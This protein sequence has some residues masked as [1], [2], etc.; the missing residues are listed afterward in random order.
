MILIHTH[1]PKS[2]KRKPTKK[3]R[4]LKASWEAMLAK[5]PSK[6]VPKHVTLPKQTSYQRETVRH[7]SLNSGLGTAT[8]K[9]PN[10]YTGTMVRGIATMH[11]SNAVPVFSDEQAVE[12]SKMR[13]G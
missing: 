10:V 3:Q 8:L 12:I 11:K 1:I 13:R 2:K 5:Y 9:P 6:S 4:E 7:P